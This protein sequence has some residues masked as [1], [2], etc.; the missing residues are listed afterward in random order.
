M[1]KAVLLQK[2]D[3]KGNKGAWIR[4]QDGEPARSRDE[5]LYEFACYVLEGHHELANRFYKYEEVWFV[6]EAVLED[7][8]LDK[9]AKAVRVWDVEKQQHVSLAFKYE[10]SELDCLD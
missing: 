7:V 10:S 3:P 2:L 4:V 1:A 6:V 9:D 5:L 8:A